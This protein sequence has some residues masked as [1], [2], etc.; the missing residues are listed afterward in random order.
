MVFS[1]H[2]SI[3]FYSKWVNTAAPNS[4]DERVITW[5][6]NSLRDGKDNITLFIQ[7]C[8]GIGVRCFDIKIEDILDMKVVLMET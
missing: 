1:R 4:I 6:V 8:K 7:T 5:P 3:E 2:F